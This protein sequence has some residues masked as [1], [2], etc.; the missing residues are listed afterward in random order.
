MCAVAEA[1]AEA[2]ANCA[3]NAGWLAGWLADRAVRP[4]RVDQALIGV[5]DD[6]DSMNNSEIR[7]Q[8]ERLKRRVATAALFVSA[9]RREIAADT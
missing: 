4:W 5:L 1:E 9:A 2:V 7:A 6:G 8:R 3:G